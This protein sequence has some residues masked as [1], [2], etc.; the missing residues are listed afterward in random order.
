MTDWLPSGECLQMRVLVHIHTFNDAS[1]IDNLLEG[2]RRQTRPA[3]AIVIIDNASTDKTLDRDFPERA[4]VIR[5]SENTGSCGAVNMGLAYGLE[6]DFDWT[7]VFDAD[8]VPEPDALANLLAFYDGLPPEQQERVYCLASNMMSAPGVPQDQPM[9]FT[10]S[11]VE[12]V[13][14]D[15]AKPAMRIDFYKWSGALF[16]MQAVSKIGLPS[17]DYFIDFGELEY[18]YRASLLGFHG[19]MVTTAAVHQDVGRLPGVMNRAA[20][21]GPFKLR[22]YDLSPLRC[23]YRVRNLIY[24]WVY[25]RRPRRPQW[26]FRSIR[27]GLFFPRNFVLRPVSCRRHLAACV[28]GFWDGLTMHMERRY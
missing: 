21:F 16:R 20:R 28:R 11:G 25:E 23:Y 7:W 3:D 24:F 15:P 9:V 2:L 19:Y 4:D 8:S 10:E 26:V 12:F 22:S 1:V 6:H 14:V 13:P 17:A 18:G 5:S 27:S